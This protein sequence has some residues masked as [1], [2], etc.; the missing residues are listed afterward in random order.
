VYRLNQFRIVFSRAVHPWAGCQCFHSLCREWRKDLFAS[1]PGEGVPTLYCEVLEGFGR[2]SKRWQ[3]LVMAWLAIGHRAG[4]YF[5]LR[6]TMAI[7]ESGA[8]LFA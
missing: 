2:D 7:R 8:F 3:S 5:L 1:F 4:R 6:H